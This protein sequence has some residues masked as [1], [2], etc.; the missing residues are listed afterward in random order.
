MICWSDLFSS[1]AKYVFVCRHISVVAYVVISVFTYFDLIK[2][3]IVSLS[4]FFLYF[5]NNWL[6]SICYLKKLFFFLGAA[7]EENPC[8]HIEMIKGADMY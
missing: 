1:S 8:G 5:F 3:F 6:K 4:I 7:P 2:S